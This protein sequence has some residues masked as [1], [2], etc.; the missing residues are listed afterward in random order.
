M[1]SFDVTSIRRQFAALSRVIAG[2]QAVYVDGPAGSQTPECVIAAIGDY[3]RNHN[4]NH[5]GAF[6]TSRENDRMLAEAQQAVADLFGVTDPS[7]IVFGA[8]MTTLTFAFS[9]SLAQTWNAGD[10]V[11]VTQLDHDANVTP[12]CMAAADRGVVVREV[13]L[14]PS[15]ATLDLVHFQQ[16]LSPRTRLVAVG[17]AS[18]ATGTL[19]PIPQIVQMAHSVGAEVFVDAVHYA[20]HGLIDVPA[21]NCDYLIASAYKFFGP[22][23]GIFWGRRERLESLT[24][25][26]VRPA[27]NHI[28]DRWMTGTPNYE[29][30]AGVRAAIDYLSC[31]GDPAAT[32]RDRL[33]QTFSAIRSHESNLAKQFLDGVSRNPG[34]TLYGIGDPARLHERVPTFA[35]RIAGMTPRAVAEYLAERGVF[36]WHGNFYALR[37][38]EVYNLEPDG[39][40]RIGLLHYNTSEEVSRLLRL[41]NELSKR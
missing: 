8:N 10:E 37:L 5:G 9:R 28:P 6:A 33:Q 14:R 13:R 34:I 19:N 4:A 25:Y 39:M 7:T 18:N 20:P 24:A 30:I 22:H 31:L 36:V 2:Q 16:L 23:V 32:R 27:D 35:L 29:C 41:L 1:S 11:I 12:W 17:C 3:L 38:S 40:V 21:W 15:D 26:K